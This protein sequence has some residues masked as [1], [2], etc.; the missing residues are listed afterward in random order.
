MLQLGAVGVQRAELVRA[1]DVE[2]VAAGRRERHN[3]RANLLDQRLQIDLFEIEV[4]LA[5]LDLRQVENVVDQIE[6][7]PSGIADL[8]KIG[9]ELIEA[10]ILGHLLQH[11]AVPD[12]GIERRTQ[13]VAHIGEE[14][15]FVLARRFELLI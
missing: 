4:H 9:Q 5:R 1:D 15:R 2:P 6:Q 10:L 13:F 14:G 11:L 3:D 8:G 7:M 12:H